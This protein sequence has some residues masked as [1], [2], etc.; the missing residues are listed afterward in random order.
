MVTIVNQQ[1]LANTAWAV[2]K[3]AQLD[4]AFFAALA[5]AAERHLGAFSP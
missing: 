4:E 5:K 2:A 1:E 3:A